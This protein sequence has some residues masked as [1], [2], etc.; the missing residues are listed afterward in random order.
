MKIVRIYLQNKI[1]KKKF[2][3]MISFGGEW[4]FRD[5]F[6]YIN[7]MGP[8]DLKLFL[9]SAVERCG[10][11]LGASC[12]SFF[13]KYYTSYNTIYWNNRWLFNTI[14]KLLKIKKKHYNYIPLRERSQ[15]MLDSPKKNIWGTHLFVDK[16]TVSTCHNLPDQQYPIILSLWASHR[17]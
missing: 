14:K 13:Y 9:E 5:A 3:R 10:L 7:T 16:T 1:W 11:F 8:L 6:L 4:L 15:K 17:P 12:I 2:L